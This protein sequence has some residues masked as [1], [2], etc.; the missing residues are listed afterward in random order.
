MA[1]VYPVLLIYGDIR[2]KGNAQPHY[3][4][5]TIDDFDINV[6]ASGESGYLH[7]VIGVNEGKIN[8]NGILDW[9]KG[10]NGKLTVQ[11]SSLPLFLLGY[12]EAF[13]DIYTQAILSDALYIRGH[14]NIPKARITVSSLESAGKRI[15]HLM[16]SILNMGALIT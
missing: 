4:I 12:G 14:V 8:C 13:A 10:A 5:G 16:R 15:L 9:A 7:G 1:V 6:K 3:N 2:L 11:A